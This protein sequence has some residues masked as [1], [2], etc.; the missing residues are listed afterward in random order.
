MNVLLY[1]NQ[2]LLRPIK[3]LKTFITLKSSYRYR[4]LSTSIIS[5]NHYKI[6]GVSQNATAKEIKKAFREK[7]L[8]CH[9]DKFP[10]DKK[11]EEE[12]KKISEAYQVLGSS[13]SK[14]KYDNEM[15]GGAFTSH[16]QRRSSDF[17]YNWDEYRKQAWEKRNGAFRNSQN[18]SFYSRSNRGYDYRNNNANADEFFKEWQK[19]RENARRDFER[20]YENFKNSKDAPGSEPP[21]SRNRGKPF[22]NAGYNDY[23]YQSERPRWPMRGPSSQFSAIFNIMIAIWLISA[24]AAVLNRRQDELSYQEWQEE[25]FIKA[26]MRKEMHEQLLRQRNEQMY[27]HN[28]PPK[29]SP[30]ANQYQNNPV[31]Q[32]Q[33]NSDPSNN[34]IKYNWQH[35]RFPLNQNQ[36]DNQ[37]VQPGPGPNGA[38]NRVYPTEDRGSSS[39]AYNGGYKKEYVTSYKYPKSH[40]HEVDQKEKENN[41]KDDGSDKR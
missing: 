34:S 22:E 11:K 26:Q 16:N 38:F 35:G 29:G 30:Y 3:N 17:D 36:P 1:S 9:P 25:Q 20:N 33:Q 7:S 4:Y 14:K 2:N 41:E 31:E 40:S 39:P 15:K 23:N 13:D 5:F 18:Q 8:K 28:F 24:F 32:Q 10:D 37:S 27:G 12:F 6:L 19:N 21:W